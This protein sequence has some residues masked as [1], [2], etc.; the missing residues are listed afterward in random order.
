MARLLPLSLAL[1]ALS[2]CGGEEAPAATTD[3]SAEASAGGEET[4]PPPAPPGPLGD[5]AFL[6][7][8][9]PGFRPAEIPDRVG[10]VRSER[11]APD[12]HLGSIVVS[13]PAYATPDQR[14]LLTSADRCRDAG[15]ASAHA[16]RR[17][18]QVEPQYVRYAVIELPAGEACQYELRIVGAERPH[19]VVGT[20]LQSEGADRVVL[21]T[22]GEGDAVAREGCEAFLE[23]W[24]WAPGER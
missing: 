24:R 14:V 1:L 23:S 21:C 13:P 19:S 8:V 16:L 3:P 10:F 6:G 12:G 9:P 4:A 5:D 18:H 17:D 15:E 11:P 2:A 7:R 22:I 20:V